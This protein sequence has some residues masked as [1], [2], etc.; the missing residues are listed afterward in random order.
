MMRR[1]I[2]S[3]ENGDPF[4]VSIGDLMAGMLAIFILA[5][6]VSMIH[7]DKTTED[8]ERGPEYRKEII[9]KI[10][11]KFNYNNPDKNAVTFEAEKGIIRITTNDVVGN[12]GQGIFESGKE[13]LTPYG[14]SVIQK[15]EQA[16][17]ESKDDMPDEW[18]AIDTVIIEGHTDRD[19]FNNNN[20]MTDEEQNLQLSQERAFQTWSFMKKNSEPSVANFMISKNGDGNDLFAVAGYGQSRLLKVNEKAKNRRIE[21]RF[22]L[23]SNKE[24]L[25]EAAKGVAKASSSK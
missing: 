8:L 11:H 5:L 3:K 6:M 20:G 23:T 22:I 13:Y 2:L 7:Y 19:G 17:A 4:S 16:M 24:L 14:I 10:E 1:R 12:S 25:K 18:K 21:F 15:L 9:N